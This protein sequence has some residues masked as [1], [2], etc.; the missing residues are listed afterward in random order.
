MS[1][2]VEVLQ[3]HQVLSTSLEIASTLQLLVETS[4]PLTLAFPQQGKS[5]RTYLVEVDSDRHTL[6]LDEIISYDAAVFLKNGEPFRIEGSNGG[7]LI[8]WECG[9][10]L[11]PIRR[12][13]CVATK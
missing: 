11:A 8:A 7:V 12:A 6:A 13:A 9:S 4:A 10:Y 3:P 1:E 2:N 5:F